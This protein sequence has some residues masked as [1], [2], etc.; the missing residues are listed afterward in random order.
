MSTSA[1][2]GTP[3]ATA[4]TGADTG[5][6]GGW[7]AP[8]HTV[9]G[10]RITDLRPVDGASVLDVG[11]GTGALTRYL[12]GRGARIVGLDVSEAALAV[13]RTRDPVGDELFRTGAAERLPADPGSQD[14]VIFSN[15]LHHVP[16]DRMDHALAEARRV[17]AP[18]GALIAIEPLAEGPGFEVSRMIDDETEVRAAALA[19]LRRAEA[20]GWVRLAEEVYVHPSVYP[21]V[22]ALIAECRQV[23][24]ARGP[25]LER[26]RAVLATAYDRFG[27][28]RGDRMLFD[29]GYRLTCL[30]PPPD[31]HG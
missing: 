1:D 22:D 18:D 28:A 7:P 5:A 21:G 14:L 26:N 27:V 13:A 3:P 19:A 24:P 10:A 11:C 9:H 25:A 2:S 20:A 30:Q 4:D 16:V 12:A 23:D 15:S 17:L 6:A 8:P 29:Q 31:V